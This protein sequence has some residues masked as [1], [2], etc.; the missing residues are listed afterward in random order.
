MRFS[1]K[2]ALV[3]K[4]IYKD[5][6]GSEFDQVVKDLINIARLHISREARWRQNRLILEPAFSTVGDYS[7][8]TATFT[9]D[10]ATV[11]FTTST[12]I[13]QGI[14]PGQRIKCTQSGGSSTVFQIKSVDSETQ[15]TLV[16]PYDDDT[17]SDGTFTILGK[18]RQTLPCYLSEISFVWHEEFGYPYVL[19]YIPEREF[20]WLASNRDTSDTPDSYYLPDPFGVDRQP[21]AASAISIISSSNAASDQSSAGVKV[22]IEGIVSSVPDI[23]EITLN[24]MTRVDGTKKFT[25]ITRCYK[26]KTTTGRITVSDAIPAAGSGSTLTTIPSGL[27]YSEPIYNRIGLSP[28]PDSSNVPINIWGYRAPKRLYNNDDVSEWSNEFDMLEILYASFLGSISEHQS[29]EVNAF[30]NAYV[31]E[32]AKLKK[33]NVDRINDLPRFMK[34]GVSQYRTRSRAFVHP[35]LAYSQF[36]PKFGPMVR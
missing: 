7:T 20:F 34:H 9:E 18:E 15:C 31:Y 32:L 8:G 29:A 12:L 19:D 24:G 23:E 22:V 2:Q 17:V 3:K 6:T 1:E 27:M 28:I 36:G 14:E 5:Q 4:N 13:T 25:H 35:R 16:K 33:K 21:S 10:S 26:T 30:F 11:T